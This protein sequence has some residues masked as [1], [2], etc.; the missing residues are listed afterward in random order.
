MSTI[1]PVL[2][3]RKLTLTKVKH[4]A[5]NVKTCENGPF[6]ILLILMVALCVPHQYQACEIEQKDTAICFSQN[7]VLG[8]LR[9]LG[10]TA[11]SNL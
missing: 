4:F 3:K 5:L 6:V 1:I 9:N 11:F 7:Y 2:Q 10:V 8:C